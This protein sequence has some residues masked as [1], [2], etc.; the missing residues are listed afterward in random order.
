MMKKKETD[1]ER[2]REQCA[3]FHSCAY[4]MALCNGATAAAAA[5]YRNIPCLALLPLLHPSQVKMKTVSLCSVG[6]LHL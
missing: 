1:R 5:A 4:R 6:G 2:E 3:A